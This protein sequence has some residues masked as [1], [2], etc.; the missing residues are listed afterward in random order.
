MNITFLG[1]GT[2]HGVP[3]LDCMI[4]DH[5][6]CPKNICRLSVADTRH[7]RTRS[8]IFVEWDG[9]N[10]VIDISL[11]FRQQ[12]LREKIKKIDG[13]LV[14]HGHADHIGGI[15]DIRSYTRLLDHPLPLYGSG[16]TLDTIKRTYGYIFDPDTFV[17]GGIPALET[18]VVTGP[19]V[20][21][22][23]TIVPLPVVH[24]ALAGCFGYRLGP[25]VYIPDM[26]SMGSEVIELCRGA[27]LLVLNCLRDTREH[28]SHMILPESMALARSIRPERCYFIHL[29]HDIHYQTDKALLDEW[30]DFSFDGMRIA[31]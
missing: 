27:K 5:A 6:Q 25:L 4:A 20:F 7:V 1:T 22:D 14:T 17:G 16:E 3:T 28:C 19:F 31:L 29:C 30:M 24:G 11:D 8:S 9:V 21:G 10:V 12:M 2:S 26:K 18:R 23:K 13:A 15:P